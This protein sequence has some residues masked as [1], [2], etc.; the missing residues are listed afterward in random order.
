MTGELSLEL[1]CRTGRAEDFARLARA[2]LTEARA[3]FFPE[4]EAGLAAEP[5]ARGPDE[6]NPNAPW[7]QPHGV[8]AQ[9]LVQRGARGPNLRQSRYSRRTWQRLLSALGSSPP[10]ACVLLMHLLDARGHPEDFEHA[11]SVEFE[12]LP[13]HPEW[14][15]FAASAPAALVRWR[16]S[17][18][19]QQRW[20][21]FLA[22]WA[23]RLDAVYGHLTDDADPTFGTA[24]E[25]MLNI[26]PED[27]VPDSDRTLRGY[28]WGTVCSPEVA[29]RVG[30]PQ[31]LR[32][33]GAFHE[34]TEL[35][36]GRLLLRA[37]PRLEQYAGDAPA[38][39]LRALAPALLHGRTGREYLQTWMR[40]A[41]DGDAA[42]YS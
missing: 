23:V 31:A 36:G 18:E 41:P 11:V 22:A 14:T 38:R 15:R 27:T 7:G 4:Y 10:Y 37:T 25:R 19:V 6:E 5:A 29:A 13:D 12:R 42:D 16:E 34:V 30:G 1:N 8:C 9:L 33:S 39:V 21:D 26:F 17:E 3:E 24:L 40:L 35:P 32:S 2:W 28:S 20:L